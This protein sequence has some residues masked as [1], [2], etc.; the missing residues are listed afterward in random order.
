MDYPLLKL[1]IQRPE[2]AG[3]SDTAIAAALNAPLDAYRDVPAAE[4]R[5]ALVECRN[6]DA[7][8]AVLRC[9]RGDTLDAAWSAARQIDDGQRDPPQMF[10]L[11]RPATRAA[12]S[13]QVGHLVDAGVL[14]MD[15]RNIMAALCR[16]TTTRAAQLGW[17]RALYPSDVAAARIY[18]NG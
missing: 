13:A 4:V 8:A 10:A 18:A 12:Y 2:Y 15:E 11:S 3:M 1:E 6:G 5:A 14:T 17:A 7:W 9:S 16:T